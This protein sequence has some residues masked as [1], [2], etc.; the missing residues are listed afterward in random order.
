[1]LMPVECNTS[2]EHL[3][4]V[5]E[6]RDNILHPNFLIICVF[7]P[8]SFCNLREYKCIHDGVE[9]LISVKFKISV[10]HQVLQTKR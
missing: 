5:C 4:E 2:V 1:M 10:G 3:R 9:K 7:C 8:S 6:E